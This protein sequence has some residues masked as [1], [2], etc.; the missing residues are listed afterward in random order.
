MADI[1]ALIAE[2]RRLIAAA[3]DRE[4]KGFP[5]PLPWYVSGCHNMIWGDD[6]DAITGPEPYFERPVANLIA[7]AVN[8][9]AALLAVAEAADKRE[10]TLRAAAREALDVLTRLADS[11]AYWSDYDVPV[12]LVAEVDSAKA[13]LAGVLR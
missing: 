10:A 11:A 13:R 8:N 6:G 4:A 2:G 5:S 1:P 12:G 7:F 3:T 9:L